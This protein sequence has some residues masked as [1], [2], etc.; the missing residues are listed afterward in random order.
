MA[1]LKHC[2]YLFDTLSLTV[3]TEHKTITNKY[4]IAEITQLNTDYLQVT[5]CLQSSLSYSLNCCDVTELREQQTRT[6]SRTQVLKRII[7]AQLLGA[8]CG[9]SGHVV[10]F[11]S[12]LGFFLQH[13]CPRQR[14]FLLLSSRMVDL[15][16]FHK[17]KSQCSCVVIETPIRKKKKTV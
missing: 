14:S 1:Q 3:P 4:T 8:K 9:F 13:W 6:Q 5:C 10:S 11:L 16:K 2:C 15:Q 17:S 7:P 12:V